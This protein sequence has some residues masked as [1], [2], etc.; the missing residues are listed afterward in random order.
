MHVRLSFG[1]HT[2]SEE[3]TSLTAE[4]LLSLRSH[5]EHVMENL[6]TARAGVILAEQE[7]EQTLS[8]KGA[9]AEVRQ[10]A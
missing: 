6:N 9:V 5:V 2:D 3:P 7:F 8:K 4:Q 10:P 1:G